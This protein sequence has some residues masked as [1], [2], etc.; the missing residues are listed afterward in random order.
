MI[1]YFVELYQSF[2][3]YFPPFTHTFISLI[4]VVLIIYSLFQTL[5]KNFIWLIVLVVLLPASIPVI[6]QIVDSIITVIKYLL[7]TS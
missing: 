4:L 1:N 5:K 6:K 7:G 2:L 3:S